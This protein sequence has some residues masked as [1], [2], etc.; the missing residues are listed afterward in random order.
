MLIVISLSFADGN[1]RKLEEV[2]VKVLEIYQRN[3]MIPGLGM[4]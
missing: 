3:P 2:Y 4:T 1:K